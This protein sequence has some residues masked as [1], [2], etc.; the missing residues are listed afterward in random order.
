MRELPRRLMTEA[1]R[2]GLSNIHFDWSYVHPWLLGE[3]ADKTIIQTFSWSPGDSVRAHKNVIAQ[4]RRKVR[5]ITRLAPN[6]SWSKAPV[7]GVAKVHAP[8][9]VA[10][11]RATGTQF[12]VG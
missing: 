12:P 10:C 3:I 5:A 1:K 11:V 4:L 9:R 7:I 8:A 6:V 2:L